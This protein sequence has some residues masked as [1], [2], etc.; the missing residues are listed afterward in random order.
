MHFKPNNHKNA[1]K[2]YNEL[3]LVL[4]HIPIKPVSETK[5]LGV[6]IDDELSWLPH[7]KYLNTKLNCGIGKLNRIRHLIPPH[8]HKNLYL[9]LFESHLSYG[10][11]AWGGVL[12]SLN[13]IFI[14][15]KSALE[16]CLVTGINT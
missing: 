6:V 3:T 1:A 13:P 14:T 11:S 12:K 16:L 2:D 15:Q 5:F 4:G 9:T 10:I 8:L 7:I